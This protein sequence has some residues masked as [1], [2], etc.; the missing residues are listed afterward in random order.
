MFPWAD[1]GSLRDFWKEQQPLRMDLDGIR[2][3]VW[4]ALQQFRGLADAFV[5]LHMDKLYR[6]GDVK[7]ENILRFRDGKT[8]TGVLQIADFGLAKQH[9]GPTVRR[10]PT[11]TR[12]TTLQYES[13][14]AEEAMKGEAAL[15]RLSD[16][17]SFGCVMFEYI[18]WLLYGSDEADRFGNDL[19]GKTH[20]VGTAPFYLRRAA[21]Q[22]VLNPTVEKWLTHMKNDPE[23][24]GDTAIGAL[25]SIIQ[26]HM[27]TT[28]I[29]R[30]DWDK[31]DHIHTGPVML[32]PGT[33]ASARESLRLIDGIIVEMR[34]KGGKYLFKGIG[35]TKGQ[36]GRKARGPSPTMTGFLPIRTSTPPQQEHLSPAAAVFRP[37]STGARNFPVPQLR[38]ETVGR[39]I[40]SGCCLS[41]LH[42]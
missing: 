4:E 3:L 38:R 28:G 14:E 22:A 21:G 41:S 18:I 42:Y 39:L 19:R 17:W 16:I 10:G 40:L 33:R 8:V 30:I 23:A 1:G 26:H 36:P 11:A 31:T 2:G 24:S 5:K 29:L 34:K 35:M 15:S 25:L 32:E 27:L 6:H 13:P 37:R 7:P 9:N 12:H 20:T